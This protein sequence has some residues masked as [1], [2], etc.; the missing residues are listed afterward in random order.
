M[1]RAGPCAALLLSMLGA[2][3]I[4]ETRLDQQIDRIGQLL[5][6][7]EHNG[8]MRCAPRQLAVA[9][10]QLEFGELERGRGFS[11]R[12]EQHLEL[13]DQNARAA[14]LL[15]PSEHCRTLGTAPQSE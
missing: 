7:A 15:S 12:A 5:I 2:G 14:K 13:A 11:S 10:S 8:A 4:R 3:C 6:D 1:R 9:R